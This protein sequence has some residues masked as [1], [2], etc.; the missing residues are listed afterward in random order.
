M[1]GMSTNVPK[2]SGIAPSAS[3]PSGDA[4]SSTDAKVAQLFS[5]TDEDIAAMPPEQQAQI[6]QLKRQLGGSA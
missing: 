3:A 4:P 1:M 5:L 6:N 2:K